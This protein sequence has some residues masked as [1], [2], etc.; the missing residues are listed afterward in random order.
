MISSRIFI[1]IFILI[2]ILEPSLPQ[3]E[4]QAFHG[5]M[6]PA[7]GAR[8]AGMG[9]AFQAVGGSVMDLESN[10]SHL[11]RVKRTKWELGSAIHLPT[12][13][14]NDEYIDPDPNRSYRNA[15]V[16]HPRAVLPYI[17]VIKPV[18]DNISIGF[19][20]YAQGG[21][22]GQ[23]KNI[24]RNTP[25]GRTLNET[26]GLNIPIIGE[27]TKTVEDLNFKFMTMKSTF[28]AGYKKGNFAIGAGIDFVYGFMEL[29]RT[30]QDETRSLTIPGGIRYQS[31]SAYTM[32]GKVGASYDL[33][34][35]I[36]VAYSYT[37]RNLLPMDGTMKVDGYA[38]E[39]SFGTRVSRYMIWPDKH[40]AGISYRT[41][42]FIID[43]DIKY[44]PWSESFNTSKF[45]LE[46]VW[47]R[48]PIGVETNTFQFNLNWKN[49]TILAVGFEY[50]WNER[51]MSRM[52]YSYGNNIIPA[53]GVSPMLG[54]SI[55][56]HLA[57]GGSISWNDTSF[58]I[59]CEYGFP[60][61]TYGG[62]TSDWTL[63]HAVFSNKEIHPF[64]F[65]YNKQM[66]IFSI[67][68]GMEQNI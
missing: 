14:Y 17:G 33:T 52:G 1:T 47:M 11:A 68:L 25:D 5:I 41:D 22:G 30:Y 61:K 13:E 19:A 40:V 6:Q 8:Q 54:A 48:T 36:R 18:T 49:Q 29:K 37:T 46:D 21:G 65:S 44:I 7:F 38:P 53:S 24:K 31:D 23:F 42:K 26:F 16:E 45:R 10:P 15:T 60:K 3:K 28:G 20:L 66:S 63:S 51:F 27:S 12:I 59:A 32:G 64:Q 43:F 58:H 39:R 35:N 50:K 55:E 56:H 62:K 57:L 34:E 4:I 2:L 9:G 67:Y